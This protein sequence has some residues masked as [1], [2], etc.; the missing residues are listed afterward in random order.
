MTY[1]PVQ[2]DGLLDLDVL[3]KAMRPDTS[4]VSVMSVNNEIGGFHVGVLHVPSIPP[5]APPHVHLPGGV[6]FVGNYFVGYYFLHS[7]VGVIQPIAE[8]GR[9]CRAGGAFLHTD[10]AQVRV[11][12]QRGRRGVRNNGLYSSLKMT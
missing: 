5:N 9:I 3:R 2:K 4:I 11:G 6:L 8:I 1:L 12:G 7:F 10:A